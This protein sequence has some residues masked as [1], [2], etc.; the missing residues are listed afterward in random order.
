MQVRHS[1]KDTVI[2]SRPS[3]K[4]N[5]S[6][7]PT[8]KTSTAIGMVELTLSSTAP[9]PQLL[10]VLSP[11]L[12]T[13]VSFLFPFPTALCATS[14]PP[15]SE[16]FVVFHRFEQ[17]SQ[18][19]RHLLILWGGNWRWIPASC[20]SP[21][22][23]VPVAE[24]DIWLVSLVCFMAYQPLMGYSMSNHACVCVCDGRGI[25]LGWEPFGS[26]HGLL[27]CN[28]NAGVHTRGR[29]GRVT[30]RCHNSPNGKRGERVRVT[31]RTGSTRRIWGILKKSV[32]LRTRHRTRRVDF[33]GSNRL[34]EFARY[35]R[36]TRCG[37]SRWK[38]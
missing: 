26:V 38:S 2:A 27:R 22:Q 36:R 33:R 3:N 9:T 34:D 16:P 21:G 10:S 6:N 15:P 17:S 23:C 25:S 29:N 18:R 20:L 1:S 4:S 24:I 12:S 31:S 13:R 30:R 28:I 7:S 19:V 14:V 8:I 37:G 35:G 11:T 5:P 32:E